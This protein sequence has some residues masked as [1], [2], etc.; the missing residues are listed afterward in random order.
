M[1]KCYTFK[2]QNLEHRTYLR[3]YEILFPKGCRASMTKH[4]QQRI[5][6]KRKRGQVRFVLPRFSL[7]F[8]MFFSLT[9][10]YLFFLHPACY[11]CPFNLRIQTVLKFWKFSARLSSSPASLVLFPVHP[12]GHIQEDLCPSQ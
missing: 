6:V 8:F 7:Y 3:L 9:M 1:E 10:L 4:R 11:W 2:G 5:K 12:T